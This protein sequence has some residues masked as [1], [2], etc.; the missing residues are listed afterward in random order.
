M[1]QDGRDALDVGGTEPLGHEGGGVAAGDFPARGPQPGRLGAG[2]RVDPQGAPV[3]PVEAPPR[4]L[5][6]GL[7]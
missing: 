3:V 5:V 7:G 6:S 2:D 1:D 4:R